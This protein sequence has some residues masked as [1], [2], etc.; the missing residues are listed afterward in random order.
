MF[1]IHIF[2]ASAYIRLV[3]GKRNNYSVLYVCLCVFSVK[4]P[5]VSIGFHETGCKYVTV[6]RRNFECASQYFT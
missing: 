4:Y 1:R 6:A 2:I 5:D 3:C